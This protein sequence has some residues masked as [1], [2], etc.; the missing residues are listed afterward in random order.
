MEEWV[1]EGSF[2]EDGN[3]KNDY[4][5]SEF[6]YNGD[7]IFELMNVDSTIKTKF[8]IESYNLVANVLE[9]E[10]GFSV[11]I[12]LFTTYVVDGTYV[13]F[14]IFGKDVDLNDFEGLTSL[15]GGF[16]VFDNKSS[17]SFNI[18]SDDIEEKYEFFTLLLNNNKASVTIKIKGD[19][20]PDSSDPS[21]QIQFPEDN[22]NLPYTLNVNSNRVEENDTISITIN[23]KPEFLNLWRSQGSII[24]GRQVGYNIVGYDGFN[25]QDLL[26]AFD[27]NRLFPLN[28]SFTLNSNGSSNIFIKIAKDSSSEGL[29]KFRLQLNSYPQIFTEIIIKDEGYKLKFDLEHP[30]D[31]GIV[32]IK[33]ETENIP[34][35][36]EVPF[37]IFVLGDYKNPYDFN[38]SNLTV[39]DDGNFKGKFIVN[40]NYSLFDLNIRKDYFTESTENYILILDNNQSSLPITIQDTSQFFPDYTSYE[41]SIDFLSGDLPKDFS[42]KSEIVE[43]D[44]EFYLEIKFEGNTGNMRDYIEEYKL[45]DNF[46]YDKF[47]TADTFYQYGLLAELSGGNYTHLL[48]QVNDF[49]INFNVTVKIYSLSFDDKPIDVREETKN[50]KL[51]ITRN[52]SSTRNQFLKEYL[53]ERRR[54][55]GEAYFHHKGVNYDNFEDYMK[56]IVEDLGFS[57]YE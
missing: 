17:I 44:K 42:V 23:L 49:V 24:E 11:T 16:Q 43:I 29:E 33:L 32:S 1:W 55:D 34:D 10:E 9:I 56:V 35:G 12:D 36:T 20:I 6:G 41:Y 19:Y 57:F 54:V 40:N 31:S 48:N 21:L 50:F 45:P 47:N 25:E 30:F 7:K 28:G 18:K 4:D 37:T 2:D 8:K 53:E 51:T 15:T 26:N 22:E 52:Y 14:T 5:N 3:I 13:P 39:D 27:P 46:S 38:N